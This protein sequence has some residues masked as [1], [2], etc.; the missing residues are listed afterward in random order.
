MRSRKRV[1][2]ASEPTGTYGDALNYQMHL[3]GLAL[4]RV[5]PKK[6]HDAAE[7]FDGVPSQHDGK[8]ATLVMA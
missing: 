6:T 8:D 3:A 7:L 5:S 4:Y 1:E 2:V